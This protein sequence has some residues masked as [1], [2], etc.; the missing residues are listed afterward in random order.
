MQ[1]AWSRAG[2]RK[3][4]RFGVSL[5]VT[6]EL[7]ERHM[8]LKPAQMVPGAPVRQTV[9]EQRMTMDHTDSVAWAEV[10]V[11]C[12]D[13]ETWRK[14]E[15]AACCRGRR[16]SASRLARTR[17]TLPAGPVVNFQPVP[18]ETVGKSRLHLDLWTDDFNAAPMQQVPVLLCARVRMGTT[19][20]HPETSAPERPA[21]A[22]LT[23]KMA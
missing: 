15:P 17:S 23:P 12:H 21:T 2:Y 14:L 4:E 20:D 9:H 19:F 7:V 11:D 6:L 18:E 8:A 1:R 3:R 10:T 16:A 5:K 13:P 22:R